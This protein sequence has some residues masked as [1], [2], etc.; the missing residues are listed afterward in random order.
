MLHAKLLTATDHPSAADQQSNEYQPLRKGTIINESEEKKSSSLSFF[1]HSHTFHA[2]QTVSERKRIRDH[3]SG[4]FSAQ[5]TSQRYT[6]ERHPNPVEDQRFI[7]SVEQEEEEGGK[8]PMIPVS[9]TYGLIYSPTF[10]NPNIDNDIGAKENIPDATSTLSTNLL[11][12]NDDKQTIYHQ[13][14]R[15][16]MHKNGEIKIKEYMPDAMPISTNVLTRNDD[17]KTVYHHLSR[18]RVHKKKST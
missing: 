6:R 15:K 8:L 7:M 11:T 4:T 16:R 14:L 18:K 2:K 3:A 10:N 13:H 12:R 17:R 5:L 1:D 9:P